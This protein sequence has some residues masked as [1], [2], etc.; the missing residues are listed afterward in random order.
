LYFFD[1]ARF[2]T[3]SK[4]GYGWFK[5]GVRTS[6]QIKLGFQNFYVYS[7]VN[8]MSG[9]DFS[10]IMPK[11]NTAVM[12]VFLDKMSQNLGYKEAIVFMD[13][14][15]WHKSKAL[16]IPRNIQVK[17]LPPYSPE[18]NPV[19]KLWQYLKSHTIKN[20][21]YD[22]LDELEDAVCKFIKS[23]DMISIRANCSINHCL[24]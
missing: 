17:Y 20:K 3:H 12:N 10:L 6:V 11:V 5:K 7:A 19:E 9:K 2:G 16:I 1:E 4:I 18:L 22:S 24:D 14:A 23:F 13:C 8:V 21:I 15:G